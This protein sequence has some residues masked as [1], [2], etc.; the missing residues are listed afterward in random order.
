[1][2]NFHINRPAQKKIDIE[3]TDTQNL[4]SPGGRGLRGGGTSLVTFHPHPNPLPSRER[5]ILGIPMFIL[6]LSLSLDFS[7]NNRVIYLTWITA[8]PFQGSP[9][10]GG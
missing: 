9:I 7:T 8:M 6:F 2:K 5:V 4:P 3:N 1:M 10:S